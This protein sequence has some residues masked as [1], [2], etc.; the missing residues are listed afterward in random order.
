MSMNTAPA[1]EAADP[2]PDAQR[3][4]LIADDDRE[5]ADGLVAPRSF[6]ISL[7]RWSPRAR[8]WWPITA[9]NRSPTAA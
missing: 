9:A 8:R 6:S 4:V 3:R 7:P 1:V 2:L 5:F